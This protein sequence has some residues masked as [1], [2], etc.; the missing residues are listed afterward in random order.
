MT[1]GVFPVGLLEAI[2]VAWNTQ[3]LQLI[4][5]YMGRITSQQQF[6]YIHLKKWYRL[7]NMIIM[8]I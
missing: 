2:S 6:V 3:Q 7:W 5:K 8:R 4:S 1:F